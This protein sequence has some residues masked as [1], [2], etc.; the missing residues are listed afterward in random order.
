MSH[1][2]GY[3]HVALRVSTNR[4]A[5][6][7]APCAAVVH[8]RPARTGKRVVVAAWVVLYCQI[9]VAADGTAKPRPSRDT[10]ISRRVDRDIDGYVVE[11]R[12]ICGFPK[13]ESV[14]RPV[15][16]SIYMIVSGCVG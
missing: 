10:G 16:Y 2:A 7:I 13:R 1:E 4:H 3:V 8:L 6:V 11:P 12:V 15:F 5:F 9:V 14:G